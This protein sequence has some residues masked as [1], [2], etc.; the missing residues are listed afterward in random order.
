MNLYEEISKKNRIRYGTEFEKFLGII[1]NQYSDRTHF[2]YEILQNAEDAEATYIRFCLERD[3]LLIYHNGRPF[4]EKDIEGV[5]GIANGTKEDGTRIGHFGIGFKSVY[6][7]TER[8]C[9][10]SGKYHF[11]IVNQLFPREVGKMNGLPDMETCIVIPFDRNDV[12]SA[13]AFAEIRDAL[14]KKI[15]AESILILKNID[16]LRID[17]SGHNEKT[18]ITKS[19]NPMDRRNYPDNVFGLSVHTTITNIVTG[20]GRHIQKDFLLFTDA[21]AEAATILFKVE[22]KE[23][24]AVKNNKIYAFFPTAKE[25]HQSFYIHAPFDTTPARD[26][27][28]EGAGYGSHNIKLIKNIGELIWFA[29][30]WMRD[31]G[32]LSVSGFNTVFPIYEYEQEDILYGIYQNSVEMIRKERILPTNTKDEFKNI[33]DICVPLWGNIVDS[34]DDEDLRLLMG[35][36]RI[37]WLAREFT[38]E[39]YAEVREFL[40]KNYDLQVLDWRN[41]VNRMTD[42]FLKQKSLEWNEKLMESIQSY[43]VNRSNSTHYINVSGIPLVRTSRGEQITARDS[44]GKLLVY[45]NNP[46][47]A[48]YKIHPAFQRSEIIRSFYQSALRI[49]EYNIEQEAVEKVLPK[50]ETVE[51][52]FITTNHIKENIEDLKIIKDA[53]FMNPNILE[54]VADKYILTDGTYWY[55]PKEM[56]IQSDDIRTGYSLVRGILTLRFL[57]HHYFDDT[58]R[59]IRLDEAFFKKLGCSLGLRQIEVTRD[60]Y[61]QAVGKYQGVQKK[62]DLRNKIFNKNYI[63]NKLNWAF[64]YEGFPQ[65]FQNMSKNRSLA[66]ARFLNPNAVNLDIFGEIVGAN[67]QH[68]SGNYVDSTM[69][70][71]MLG[72]MLAHEKWIYIEGDSN[73]HAPI[74]IDKDDLLPEYKAVKRLIN[75]LP[76]KEVKSAFMEFLEINIGNKEDIALVKHYLSDPDQLVKVAKAMAKREAKDDTKKRKPIKDLIENGNREQTSESRGEDGLDIIGISGKAMEKRQKALEKAFA[77][78]LDQ[79]VAFT[80]GISFTTHVSNTEEREFLKYEYGGMCQICFKSIKRFN[81]EPYFEA[82]NIVKFNDLPENLGNSSRFGWNSLCLCPNC[83][84]EYNYSSK[85]ISSMYQQ[86]MEQQVEADS[87]EPIRIEIEMPA[88]KKRYISYSPRHFMAL[89]QA[90]KIFSRTRND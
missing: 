6:C 73:P 38:T 30:V 71:S 22:G 24:Q 79:K 90:L 75:I 62:T 76:F 21:N 5:C 53:I 63:S 82:I 18:H 58:E 23:I 66:I 85:K 34:F 74:E 44:E 20:K 70:Y 1:I 45:L 19:M 4:N 59:N 26:N 83:A 87:D 29:F 60:T 68:F 89:Q 8:P 78:T 72:L 13:V 43:C 40:K 42:T 49:P 16:D 61:L 69:A 7:Y 10:Y 47:V 80:S 27:F 52:R 48:K 64:S 36:H 41:L 88:G 2:I 32:Y 54:K 81:G 56:Y 65:I 50:Y 86:V 11:T 77:E 9:I 17:I 67:D 35:K 51:P 37:S 33:S 46:D 25:S 28:K 84:A 3:R 31:H 14:I 57:S 55:R 12:S 15:N 39:A